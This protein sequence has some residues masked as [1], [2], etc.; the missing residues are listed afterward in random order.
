MGRDGSSNRM[1]LLPPRDAVA[2]LQV[3]AEW[4]SE[5]PG[6]VSISPVV[7]RPETLR[8]VCGQAVVVIFHR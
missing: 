3:S 2:F 5:E 1:R 7:A 6:S 8:E 4:Q